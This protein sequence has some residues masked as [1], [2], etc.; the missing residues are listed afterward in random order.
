[1]IPMGSLGNL[2]TLCLEAAYAKWQLKPA[3]DT[4]VANSPA[5]DW[6]LGKQSKMRLQTM[7]AATNRSQPDTGFAGHWRQP[8]EFRIPLD[9]ACFD[10]LVAFLRG[11]RAL[12]SA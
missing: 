4:F 9:H 2:E 7:L 11:F 1:M 3:L 8:L 6:S 10:D 5:R 12:I